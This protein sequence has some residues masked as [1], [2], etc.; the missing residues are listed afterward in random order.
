MLSVT[1]LSVQATGQGGQEPPQSTPVS[2]PFWMP[3][4]QVGPPEPP[5]HPPLDSKLARAPPEVSNKARM[6]AFWPAV[7]RFMQP[8][9]E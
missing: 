6:R 2:V 9:S 1:G 5:P 3:S 4:E 8:S 7:K